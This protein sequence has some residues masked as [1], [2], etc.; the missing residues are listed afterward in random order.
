MKKIMT[1]RVEANECIGQN[2]YRLTVRAEEGLQAHAG[3]FVNIYPEDKATL[4]P[5]PISIN[6]ATNGILTLVFRACGAGTNQIA[7]YGKGT[8]LRL[9]TPLGNGYAL[10]ADYNHARVL[11]V[12]GGMGAAPLLQLADELKARNTYV[13]AVIGFRSVPILQKEFESVCDETLVAT[14]DGSA[15]YRGSAVELIRTRGLN[16]A[17]A[18]ACGPKP[19]LKQL[20]VLCG[21]SGTP[22]FVSLEERMGCGYGACVGCVCKVNPQDGTGTVH[23]CVC[24]DGPV[25]DAREVVWA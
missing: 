21:K 24:K 9:S 13:T 6:R 12:G 16:A 20:T 3:Q 19:M 5:R 23:K 15:G 25:F 10:Q 14:E 4:L 22:L 11:L 1:G 17:A 7:R 2:V 18:F 8:S